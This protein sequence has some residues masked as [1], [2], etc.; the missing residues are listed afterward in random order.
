MRPLP[1]MRGEKGVIPKLQGVIDDA[2]QV[3]SVFDSL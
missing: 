3:E 1:S 2:M